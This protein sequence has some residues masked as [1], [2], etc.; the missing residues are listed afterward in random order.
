M[1]AI[2][3]FLN[4]P[5]FPPFFESVISEIGKEENVMKDFFFFYLIC[6]IIDHL[7]CPQIPRSPSFDDTVLSK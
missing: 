5:F 7:T 1:I 6:L 4:T 2:F 3:V